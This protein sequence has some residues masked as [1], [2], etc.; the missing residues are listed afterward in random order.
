MASD[1]KYNKIG[2]IQG[3][4]HPISRAEKRTRILPLMAQQA[5]CADAFPPYKM[6]KSDT[7]WH[8][9]FCN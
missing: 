6:L 9:F 1:T 7:E 5:G 2:A 4:G 8:A 3:Q